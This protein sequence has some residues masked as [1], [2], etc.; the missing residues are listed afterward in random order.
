MDLFVELFFI[1]LR[2]KHLPSGGGCKT[3]PQNIFNQHVR[4]KQFF[5]YNK[6][7]LGEEK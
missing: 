4:H 6:T 1:R 7:V 2:R 3:L 5:L